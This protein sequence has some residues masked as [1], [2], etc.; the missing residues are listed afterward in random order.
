[1]VA[2]NLQVVSL[3]EE[4][5]LDPEQIAEALDLEVSAV[6]FC[7]TA[8][9]VSYRKMLNSQEKQELPGDFLDEDFS[10]AANAI[11]ELIFSE[12]D[13]IRYRA[14]KFIYNEKKGRND[15][16]EINS[17]NFNVHLINEQMRKA[18]EAKARAKELT[19]IDV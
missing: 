4:S 16:K 3:Y 17:V 5:G 13:H 7:L 10:N 8:H 1:M 6:K 11:K 14:A 2:G 18:I 19:T 9:S 15:L 12:D